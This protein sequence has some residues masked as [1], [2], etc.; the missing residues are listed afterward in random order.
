M[1]IQIARAVSNNLY[2]KKEKGTFNYVSYL[3]L[4]CIVEDIFC[5]YN[6]LIT[7]IHYTGSICVFR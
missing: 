3:F 5:R 6:C 4:E 2:P 7:F 1:R